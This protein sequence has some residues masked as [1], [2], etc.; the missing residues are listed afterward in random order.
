ME[1]AFATFTLKPDGAIDHFTMVA[2]SL[3]ADFN[4]D[5][6]DLYLVPTEP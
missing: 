5:Y 3:V 6:Q 4:F 2:V 1:D